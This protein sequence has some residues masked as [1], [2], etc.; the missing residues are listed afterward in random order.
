MTQELNDMSDLD[1]EFIPRDETLRAA[2]DLFLSFAKIH[3]GMLVDYDKLLPRLKDFAVRLETVKADD[4]LT[5]AH[6]LEAL[7]DSFAELVK[8][9][10]ED[11]QPL[12]ELLPVAKVEEDEKR[13]RILRAYARSCDRFQGSEL[14]PAFTPLLAELI[15]AADDTQRAEATDE[16]RLLREFISLS[17]SVIEDTVV[18]AQLQQ[19]EKVVAALINGSEDRIRESGAEYFSVVGKLRQL[20]VLEPALKV[21]AGRMP[22]IAAGLKRS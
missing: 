2:K 9:Y 15:G 16:E 14:D 7:S 11:L 21:M 13:A 17:A 20:L 22:E 3:L 5:L 8:V 6:T 10:R 4:Q 19:A 18:L 12:L 1:F